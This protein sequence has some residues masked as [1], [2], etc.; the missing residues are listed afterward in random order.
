[1]GIDYIVSGISLVVG[2]SSLI[3]SL[4]FWKINHNN[5]FKK[6]CSS[7]TLKEAASSKE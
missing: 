1:M 4:V 6:G 3:I 5:S 7:H 2:L